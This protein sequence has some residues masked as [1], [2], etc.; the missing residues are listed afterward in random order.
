M[1]LERNYQKYR[2]MYTS[3]GKLVFGGKSAE[4]NEEVV[5]WLIEEAR[6]GKDYIVMHTSTPGSPFAVLHAERFDDKD[7]EEC[8]IFC[9]C[10]SRAWR[11]KEKKVKIDIFHASQLFKN[12]GM[13]T[14]TFG[15]LEKTK[16]KNVPLRLCLELQ[17]G[18]LRGV[19]YRPGRKSCLICLTPGKIPKEKAAELI[20]EC[21]G[22]KKQEILE[23]L[24]TGGFVIDSI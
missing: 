21:I 20:G 10:F 9:A 2:W 18:V 22:F 17:D 23:A 19:P 4:Q 6:K 14:G 12:P 13:K 3:S 5:Q 15:V 1:S 24:P 11:E 16:S 8:A 7:L